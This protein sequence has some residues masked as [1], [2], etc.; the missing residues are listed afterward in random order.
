VIVG[1]TIQAVAEALALAERAGIDPR[2]VQQALAGGSADSR[3]LREHG[4]RMIERDYA[5]RASVQTML[6]DTR[7]AL[8]LAESFGREFPHLTDLASRWE[9]LVAEGQGEADCSV[10]FSLLGRG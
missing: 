2:L 5:A 10:L 8:S 9:R 4:R 6:K 7:L 3:I 1:L